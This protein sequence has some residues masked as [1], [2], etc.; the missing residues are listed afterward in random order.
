V[1]HERAKDIITE[2][3]N[4][5][6]DGTVVVSD[7]LSA[8]STRA[9]RSWTADLRPAERHHARAGFQK[10]EQLDRPA[11]PGQEHRHRPGLKIRML[12]A[13]KRE[14]VKDFQS[15]LEFDQSAMFKKVYEEEFGTFG[16]APLAR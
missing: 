6:M 8:T 13:T 16:G 5:V 15:A 1:E 14:L 9:W 11:L 3:V 7:N 2:L 4:Q 12:N 10:L